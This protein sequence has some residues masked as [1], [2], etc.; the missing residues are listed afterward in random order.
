MLSL[1]PTSRAIGYATILPQSKIPPIEQVIIYLSFQIHSIEGKSLLSIF[2]FSVVNILN[3]I[4][5][6]A[7]ARARIRVR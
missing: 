7:K 5:F 1:K 6:A 4:D 2:V 3:K